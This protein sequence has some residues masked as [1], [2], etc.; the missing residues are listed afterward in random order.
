M[1]D[2]ASF[3]GGDRVIRHIDAVD[4]GPFIVAGEEDLLPTVTN[5]VRNVVLDFVR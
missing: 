1:V 2:L 4:Y 3:Q 5:S